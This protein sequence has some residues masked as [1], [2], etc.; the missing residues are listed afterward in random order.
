MPPRDTSA[1]LSTLCLDGPSERVA[2]NFKTYPNM[3]TIIR[4]SSKFKILPVLDL[5]AIYHLF[6]TGHPCTE[7]TTTM[8]L[9]GRQN[10]SKSI[11]NLRYF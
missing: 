10:N 3:Q 1:P 9:F 8:R 5:Q 6:T 4:F 2:I 11:R 7:V